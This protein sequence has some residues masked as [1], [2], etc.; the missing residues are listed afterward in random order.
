MWGFRCKLA[1]LATLMLILSSTSGSICA[2]AVDE[3]DARSAIA[4]AEERI[5]VCYQAVADADKAGANTT[6]L[7]AVLNE[8]GENLSRAHLAYETGD[9]DSALNFTLLSQE[10]L[11]GFSDEANN[12]RETAIQQQYSDFMVNIVGSIVGTAVVICCSFVVWFFLKRRY[13]KAEKAI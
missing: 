10:T 1:F 9:F 11:N 7:L 5:V 13:E 6:S 8:A 4:A 3:T 12:L 2:F